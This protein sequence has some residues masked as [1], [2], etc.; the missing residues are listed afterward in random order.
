MQDVQVSRKAAAISGDVASLASSQGCVVGSSNLGG[1]KAGFCKD[2]HGELSGKYMT[3][4]LRQILL[5]RN[6]AEDVRFMILT[7]LN[8]DW[9][10]VLAQWLNS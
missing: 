1:G 4:L 6:S 9:A 5:L 10:V 8:T 2:Q 3:T 7:E